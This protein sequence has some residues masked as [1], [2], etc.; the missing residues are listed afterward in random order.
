VTA[1]DDAIAE[2]RANPQQSEALDVEGN[3]VVLAP[4]GS[5]KTK[6]LTVRMV[7]DLRDRIREPHGAACITYTNAAAGELVRRVTELGAPRRSNLFIGTVHAFAI[8]AIL[9]PYAGL[10]GQPEARAPIA[11]D[12]ERQACYRQAEREFYG[13]HEDRRGVE[14]TVKLRRQHLNYEPGDIDAGGERTAAV[15]RRWD[16]LLAEGGLV[17]FEG[18]V[19]HSVAVVEDH[20]W[21]RR[22]LAARFPQLFLDEYQD[23]APGLDR[24]ARALCFDESADADLFAV[25]DPDQSIMGFNGSRPELLLDL[26]DD[27]RVHCVRLETNY[28]SRGRIVQTALRALG[29]ERTITWLDEG[30]DI[31][32]HECDRGPDE[33]FERM[34]AI[35]ASERDA[36]TPLEQVAV[37]CPNKYIKRDA[38]Q[39]LDD[40]QIPAFV[41]GDEY[42]ETPV[43]ALVESF[44]AWTT[45]PRGESGFRLGD[46]LRRWRMLMG[47][48]DTLRRDVALIELL[49]AHR[50]G[51]RR[52]GE[53]AAA[54][55][56][57]GLRIRL[58][59][60]GRDDELVELDKMLEALTTGELRQLTVAGLGRRGHAPGQVHISTIH[61]GKGLEFEAVVVIALDEGD[62][63]SYRATT[64]R[65]IEDARRAFYVSLTR[66]KR[67]VDLLY[68][69]FRVT[70]SGNRQ[71]NGRCRFLNYID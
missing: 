47:Q 20:Q 68:S 51:D 50:A 23:L 71:M 5:G 24:L 35:V 46:L 53:F 25:G 48:R 17:D 42:R 7:R 15:A 16:E 21:V 44:A 66:A 6:L 11:T 19:R 41:R 13:N 27:A 49:F 2:L 28:R 45:Q 52:A 69:G 38:A 54:I 12:A 37:L 43:T 58:R 29:E 26:A 65:E 57:L 3:C 59:R 64:P 9:R 10:T 18:V 63:P 39:A 30:G 1:L 55:A 14:N 61:A 60:T 34:V 56:A 8:R 36:A 40:A 70:Q 22:A 31:T 62:F 4:P 67:R 33:Q 32:L